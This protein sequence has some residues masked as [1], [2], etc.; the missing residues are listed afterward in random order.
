MDS[1]LTSS[2]IAVASTCRKGGWRISQCLK[3]RC[4]DLNCPTDKISSLDIQMYWQAVSVY[5]QSVLLVCSLSG[6]LEA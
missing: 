3:F 2:W 5:L 6:N 1:L 4:V